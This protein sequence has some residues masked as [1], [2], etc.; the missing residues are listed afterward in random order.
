[1]TAAA[2]MIGVALVTFASVF[3]ASA[4]KTVSAQIDSRLIGQAVIQNGNGFS[5]FAPGAA[6]AAAR[7]PGVNRV[8]TLRSSAG[9]LVRGGDE[10]Q[11]RGIDPATLRALYKLPISSGPKDAVARLGTN[12]TILNKGFA[13]AHHL[14]VGSTFAL[15]TPLNRTT[16]LRVV[17]LTDDSTGVAADIT[18]PNPLVQSA[19]GVDRDDIVFVGYAPGTDATVV[20][21]RLKATLT[22]EFP[23]VQTLTNGE[24]KNQQAGQIDQLLHIIF[25]LLGLAIVVSLF[26]IVNT[27]VLSIT[28][29]TRELALLRAIGTSRR[30]VRSMI[31]GESVIIALIGAILGTV[32]GVALAVLVSRPLHNLQFA[33]PLGTI[34]TVL[35]LGV[36]A[37]VLAAI[38]PARRAS[39]LDVLQSLAHE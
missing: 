33:F 24:F 5:S 39:K 22:R 36:L 4:N 1:V 32:L 35:I 7:V 27:L 15:L 9:K 3:A 29:R 10:A 20:T 31:R 11:V 19:F 14:R 38:W 2:L 26:G 16:R 8:G 28:E 37:G 18:V 21:A 12:G 13:S 23:E 17:A 34:V 25:A 6:Q 30:Q